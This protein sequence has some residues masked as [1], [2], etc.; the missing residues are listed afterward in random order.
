MTPIGTQSTKSAYHQ[1]EFN[2]NVHDIVTHELSNGLS[3]KLMPDT[4][5]IRGQILLN[6]ELIYAS[7]C[8]NNPITRRYP[9]TH[10]PTHPNTLSMVDLQVGHNPSIPHCKSREYVALHLT[11]CN[12]WPRAIYV[13]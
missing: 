2:G 1:P 10:A 5:V 4:H 12:A 9:I 8:P 13:C 3:L 6:L 7:V 11:M